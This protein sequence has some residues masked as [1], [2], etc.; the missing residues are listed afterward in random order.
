ME[1]RP[2]RPMGSEGSMGGR[3]RPMG[4]MEGECKEG[5]L[6]VYITAEES[7]L[8]KL[9]EDIESMGGKVTTDYMTVD[10]IKWVKMDDK[11]KDEHKDCENM[12]KMDD[13]EEVAALKKRVM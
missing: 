7:A 2:E 8:K 4:S 10:S 3:E 1:E 6:M 9:G 11:D 12:E 5:T 13:N